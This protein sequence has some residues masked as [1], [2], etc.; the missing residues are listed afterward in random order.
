MQDTEVQKMQE[1]FNR[2]LREALGPGIEKGDYP[3]DDT[4]EYEPY[5]DDQIENDGLLVGHVSDRDNFE[6]DVYDHYLTAEVLLPVQGT[7]KTGFVWERA[8]DSDGKLIGTKNK[9]L[10]LDTRKYVVEFPDGMEQIYSANL[11][12]EDMIA[13][14]DE[15]GNQF[16]LVLD[17]IV[18][19]KSDENAILS[20]EEGYFYHN[21]RQYQKKT[22]KGWKLCVEWKDRT[23]TW[24]PLSALKESTLVKVA[25]YAVSNKIDDETRLCLV[26]AIYIE[27]TRVYYLCSQQTLL[28]ADTQVWYSSPSY[29]GRGF[30]DRQREQQ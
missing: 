23:T 5:Q 29:G 15:E 7:M 22:T 3:E 13:Q 12:A 10:L 18:D 19:H 28:E 9:H 1:V 26:G 14:C 25:Q 11:L 2:T 27:E 30:A 6:N 16:I 4:P 21:N 8:L 20:K 24:E 17:G